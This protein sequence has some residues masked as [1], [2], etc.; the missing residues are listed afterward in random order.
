LSVEC[1]FG[2]HVGHRPQDSAALRLDGGRAAVKRV[3][4][5]ALGK[6]GLDHR[7]GQ[8]RPE[9]HG[10]GP[11]R[12]GHRRHGLVP[13]GNRR[14]PGHRRGPGPCA[15]PVSRTGRPDR[16][17]PVHR[18]RRGR[19]LPESRSLRKRRIVLILGSS[20]AHPRTPPS[21][22]VGPPDVD[23][24]HGPAAGYR[25][26]TAHGRVPAVPPPALRQHPG[27]RRL[28]RVDDHR[29][30]MGRPTLT[31]PDDVRRGRCPYRRRVQQ[32]PRGGHRDRRLAPLLNRR[33]P[34][35]L[36]GLHTAGFG[37]SRWGSR[38]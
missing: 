38:A 3:A 27:L 7:H 22:L 18:G 16:L 26:R 6:P 31:G 28:R 12:R 19:G 30:R 8:P 20:T 23:H 34:G 10:T 5:A 35:P 33:P 4:T 17:H 24:R 14:R 29:D 15:V 36:S 2:P 9:H 25:R 11:G 32:R 21:D 1:R 13:S 37:G